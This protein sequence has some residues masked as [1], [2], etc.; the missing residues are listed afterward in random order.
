MTLLNGEKRKQFFLTDSAC[1]D[2]WIDGIGSLYS[3]IDVGFL[4]CN[5]FLQPPIVNASIAL[6]CFYEN[7]TMIYHVHE[8]TLCYL[9]TIGINEISNKEDLITISPNPVTSAL[10]IEAPLNSTIEILNL[11]GQII[12]SLSANAGNTTIDV[13]AFP[14]GMYFVEIK[15]KSGVGVRKFVKE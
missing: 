6:V 12:N 9:V 3:L 15:S 14:T 11:Q 13:S 8:Y 1:N 10:S 4:G 2:Q 7:D 5:I